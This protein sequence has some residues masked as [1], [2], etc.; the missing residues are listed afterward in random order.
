VFDNY[1]FVNAEALLLFHNNSAVMESNCVHEHLCV[2]KLC[3]SG[4]QKSAQVEL[5]WAS[6][7]QI[8]RQK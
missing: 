1:S 5:R 8:R 6:A 4:T 7:I 2:C 3:W